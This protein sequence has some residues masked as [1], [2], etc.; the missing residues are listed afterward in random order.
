VAVVAET[1]EVPSVVEDPASAAVDWEPRFEAVAVK[2]RLKPV[3]VVVVMVVTLQQSQPRAIAATAVEVRE[4]ME[5]SEAEAEA[6]KFQPRP[7][8]FLRRTHLPL[9]GCVNPF[10]T[11]TAR[12]IESSRF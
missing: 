12:L 8:A 3:K 11:R 5:Q 7:A 4:W 1:K 6:V 9:C 2:R 10:H